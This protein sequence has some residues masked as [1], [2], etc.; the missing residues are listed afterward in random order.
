MTS[1]PGASPVPLPSQ[2]PTVWTSTEA[3]NAHDADDCLVS[4]EHPDHAFE[5]VV[6]VDLDW[7][8]FGGT[9]RDVEYE[10]VIL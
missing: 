10:P 3:A 5:G 8:M 6:E 7:L 2:S 4:C 9:C 1:A